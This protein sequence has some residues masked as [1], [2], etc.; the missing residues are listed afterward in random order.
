MSCLRR[1]TVIVSVSASI[2]V[3][4]S[5]CSNSKVSQC[6]RLISVV[7]EGSSLVEDNKGK[8][9]ATTFQ[10][11]QDLENVTQAIAQIN[12]EDTKLKYFQN[13]FVQVFETL[14]QAISQAGKALEIAN[15]VEVSPAA[16]VKLDKAKAEI[17][18]SFKAASVAAKQAD[19]LAG[20]V[21]RYCN[22]DSTLAKSKL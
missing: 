19:V 21:N 1:Y 5:G 7:N 11:A 12:L 8:E 13:R 9:A 15:K 20:E 18:T 4:V 6:Q 2:A 3:L 10:L 16:R 14:S 17:E 22:Q